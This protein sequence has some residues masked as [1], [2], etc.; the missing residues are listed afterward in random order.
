MFLK[1]E[2]SKSFI[3]NP[4][5]RKRHDLQGPIDDAFTLPFVCV[6]GT[7]TS[8]TPQQNEWATSVLSLFEK[9]FDKWL[10]AKVPVIKDTEVSD[11]DI[12]NKNLI[13]FGDPGSNAMIAKVLEDLPVEWTKEYITV[14]GKKYDTQNHGVALIY[15]N[16]LN[17]NRYV[18]INSGHT[19][20]EKRFSGF[21]LLAL[22]QAGRYCRPSSFKN[23]K[24]AHLKMK[25][26]GQN[27]ST[28]IGN[29][30]ETE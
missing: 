28:A 1:Y 19:M 6:T 9:E 30:P 15:P 12:Q 3:E 20:H 14:N 10:R 16:P 26:S 11:Q 4:N 13:L 8:W 2:D 25:P 24:M 17:P 5:L 21:Q 29:Y 18:V 23:K 22:S 7:G 27:Y